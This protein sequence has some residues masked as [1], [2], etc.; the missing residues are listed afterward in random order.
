MSPEAA[1]KKMQVSRADH[2]VRESFT[3][4]IITIYF[5]SSIENL[6]DLVVKFLS[7]IE[8]KEVF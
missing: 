2:K 4:D 3:I 5:V 7:I 6:A 1:L 8:R